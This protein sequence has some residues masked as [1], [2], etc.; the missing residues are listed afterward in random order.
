LAGEKCVPIALQLPAHNRAF[1][2]HQS[3][4][5]NAIFFLHKKKD[6]GVRF[7]V[8]PS[9]FSKALQTTVCDA[10]QN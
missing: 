6:C 7:P 10:P 8:T 4:F 3:S 9:A 5:L 2:R 1:A